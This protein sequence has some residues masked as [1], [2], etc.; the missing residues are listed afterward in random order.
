MKSK[1]KR[2]MLWTA[3][4]A[5][6]VFLSA[7]VLSGCKTEAAAET[8][9]AAAETNA[10]EGANFD[11]QTLVISGSTT[12]LEVSNAWAEAFM[13]KFGGEITVNGGGSGVGIA[14]AINGSNDLGNASRA[15]KD[16][17]IE[18]AKA[19]GVDIEEHEVLFDGIS[20]VVSKNIDVK[21]LTIAQL[22]DI[23]VGNITNWKDV[24]GP[25][26]E[27]IAVARDSSSGTGEFFLE[28]V[29]TLD[30]EAKDND[31]GDQCLRLQSNADVANQVADNDNCIGYIGLGYLASV[32]GKANVVAVI[33]EDSDTGVLPSVATVKDGTYPISRGLYVYSNK[34]NY[35]DFAKTFV[36]FMMSDEGQAIGAEA[37]FVPVG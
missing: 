36:E 3:V 2:I 19:A 11:G 27:I 6:A 15:I 37:G 28:R 10:Q 26:A 1:L 22:S 33:A 4:V 32:E 8:T 25:D 14:D 7:S 34:N 5:V 31:Y 9:A 12:L 24:G 23:Y 21:E 35:S 18:E 17:E 16:K 29:V 20:V 30:G 13:A